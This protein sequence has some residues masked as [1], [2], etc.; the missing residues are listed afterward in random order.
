LSSQPPLIVPEFCLSH[1]NA[2]F[3]FKLPVNNREVVRKCIVLNNLKLTNRKSNILDNFFSEYLKILDQHLLKIPES[4]SSIDLHKLTYLDIRK[5]SFL[6]SDIVQEARKDSW[7]MKRYIERSGYNGKFG[8]KS[9]SIRLNQRWFKFFE[10]KRGTPCFSITYS[11]KKKF[12]IPTSKDRQFQRFES[13]LNDGWVFDNISLLVN[14]KISVVLEKEFPKPEINQ[15]FVVGIDIGSSTLASV[16]VFDTQTSKV[17]KQLY[18]GRDVAKR[19]RKY[20]QRRNKL[21]SLADKGSHRAKQ[22]LRKLKYKQF[23]FVKTRSG[24]ISKE[25]VNL[26]KSYNAYISIEKLKNIRAKKGKINK[27]GRKKINI[28]PYGKFKEFLKS[29]SEMFQVPLYEVDAYHTSK[30][31]SHCGEINNGH[32][33]VNYAL[34]K[35]RK[36]GQVVN[37]DRKASLVIAVKSVLERNIT[38]NLTNLG[39]I[40]ISKTQVSVN[41]LLRPNEV[42]LNQVVEQHLNQP[43][44]S[45]LR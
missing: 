13:F 6:S 14:G 5:T 19:Q 44:E 21:K 18:F 33:S 15:R 17:V 26:A 30:W 23:N 41:A 45:H 4:F 2:I 10:T 39:S 12:V 43:M 27:N 9:C 7:K 24:Q 31:C 8:F 29:N 1:P 34:Y 36:C 11:P 35:C 20:E 42:G 37:S 28:I 22:S 38:H 25:I 3:K 16:T 40:Q 32:S